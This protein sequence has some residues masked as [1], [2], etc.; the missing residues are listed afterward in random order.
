MSRFNLSQYTYGDGSVSNPHE[1]HGYRPAVLGCALSHLRLWRQV[2]EIADSGLYDAYL[3]VEDD[4][5]LVEDFADRFRELMAVASR[6][7]EW[8]ILFLGSLDDRPFYNDS[9]LSFSCGASQWGAARCLNFPLCT[10]AQV[11]EAAC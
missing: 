7:F 10:P 1:D 8:D 4:V 9:P 11:S 5:R 2:A 3:I 6:S